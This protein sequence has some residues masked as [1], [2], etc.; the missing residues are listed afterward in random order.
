MKP[1][2]WGIGS[3]IASMQLSSLVCIERMSGGGE[4]ISRHP[5]AAF[6]ILKWL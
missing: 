5:P 3:V 6:E 4:W 2:A 1:W